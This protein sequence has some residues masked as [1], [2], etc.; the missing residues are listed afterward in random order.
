MELKTIQ[1]L[2][3][4]K[5]GT[6]PSPEMEQ[7]LLRVVL[8][9][10]AAIF[11]F[12]QLSPIQAKFYLPVYLG[13]IYLPVFL[14][15][16]QLFTD[17]QRRLAGMVLDLGTISYGI[18]LAGEQGAVLVFLYL[19]ITIG[20]GFRYGI[21]YLFAAQIASIVSFLLV[22]KLSSHWHEH[23]MDSI[24]ILLTM[25]V[26]PL[27]AAK[28]ISRLEEAK[29]KAEFANRAKSEFVANMSHEI[30]TP[31][32]GVIGLSDLLEQTS[33]DREQTEMVE[34]IQSSAHSLLYL[35]NDILDF[36]KIEAGEFESQVKEIDLHGIVKATVRMLSLQ[37][38]EKGVL[39]KA[40]IDSSIPEYVVGDDQHIRQVLINLVGNAVKFTDEGEIDVRVTLGK[41]DQEGLPIR[42]EIIDTGVGIPFEDQA[43]IFDSFQQVG[44]PLEQMRTG[45]GLGVTISR[46]LV[47]IMGGEL[48]LQSAPGQGSRFW[49]TLPLDLC[50]EEEVQTAPENTELS[51]NTVIPFVRPVTTAKAKS[52]KLEI[53][54]AEDNVVNRKVITM[55]LE[56][57]GFNV[58][59]VND[60]A[61]ALEALEEDHHYDLVIVDMQMPVMGGIEAMKMYRM[62]HHNAAEKMPFLVLTANATTD[63]RKMCEE[64]GA[65][66]F[67]TK[68]V[69][70]G[71]L[72]HHVAWLTGIEEE[73]NKVQQKHK[74][75][76][77]LIF[78]PEILL[79][80]STIRTTPG[81]LEEMIEMFLQNAREL[82][83]GMEDDIESSNLQSL[84]DHAHAMKGSAANVGANRI[85]DACHAAK[86][87]EPENWQTSGR[88]LVSRLAT[89]F[90]DFERTFANYVAGRNGRNSNSNSSIIDL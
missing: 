42:F 34:T 76:H 10:L 41:G 38:E 78:D 61:L 32:N 89:E 52:T 43:R 3:K 5:F 6:G 16:K 45:T 31:L 44:T 84:K 23:L 49:F 19:F 77:A 74:E 33:L 73:F 29:A 53:L 68:P 51:G 40:S 9:T 48:K 25:A 26:I 24:G 39:I 28:L 65:D 64:A 46:E 14:I 72:L 79:E 67:L 21:K 4:N 18:F 75:T 57:A 87:L 15:S 70:S 81:A 35:V 50:E 62:A 7:A 11:V 2:V 47:R 13:L 37:A 12:G 60:G 80:L 58:H 22:I 83:R 30:R 17:T 88:E 8:G 90:S 55:I 63:A 59:T 86:G 27:Y 69:D 71:R 66:A 56:N 85:S 36:S 82:Y 54:V 1:E 20:N